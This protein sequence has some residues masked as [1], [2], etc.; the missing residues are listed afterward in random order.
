MAE[1]APA[2]DAILQREGTF[3]VPKST[4]CFVRRDGVK[5]YGDVGR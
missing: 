3:R 1:V 4:G 2:I 5:P